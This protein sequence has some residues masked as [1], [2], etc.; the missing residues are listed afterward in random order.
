MNK[1]ILALALAIVFI[2][3][4]FT[5]CGNKLEMTQVGKNE[6]PLAEDDKGETITN[7]DGQIA[8]LVTDDN[9]EVPTYLDGEDQTYWIDMVYSYIKGEE[10]SLKLGKGWTY[11]YDKNAYFKDGSDENIYV[12]VIEFENVYSDMDDYVEKNMDSSS[13][14]IDSI[15]EAYPDTE[16]TITDGTLTEEKL[17]CKIIKTKI[18]NDE[19]VYYY[20]SS[21]DFIYK[22]KVI[23]VNYV[24]QNGEYEEIDI[25]ALCN[26]GFSIDE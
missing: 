26:E 20:T 13:E 18:V 9:G 10:Y 4:A 12:K 2:A 15:I 14:Y 11:S 22:D 5:A 6:Y 3:T 17:P 16:Y 19:G 25:L 21:I 8:V 23:S 7:E 1:K 24:C